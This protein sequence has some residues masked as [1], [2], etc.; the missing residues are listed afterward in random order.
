M[1]E[2]ETGAGALLLK[3]A[4]DY[5]LDALETVRPE[6]WSR[7]TPCRDWNLEMLLGHASESVAA[8]QEGLDGE[9]IGL[10]TADHSQLA[11]ETVHIL[12]LRLVR[13]RAGW[14]NRKCRARA[15]EVAGQTLPPSVL[16]CV[17]AL[18][19]AI[20]GWDIAQASGHHWPIPPELAL[21]L[22]A[23]SPLLMPDGN[24]HPL[25][26]SPV[27]VTETAGPSERVLAFLGRAVPPPRKHEP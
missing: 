9:P 1:S 8:I 24:R 3:Q 11:I 18:E 4:V 12:R 22:L 26:A 21:A 5:S 6:F 13:L 27:R 20:H 2:T 17:A 10:Y 23:I 14:T 7:P 16:R 19:I 25:F 15:V